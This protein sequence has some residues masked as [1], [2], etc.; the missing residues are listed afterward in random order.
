[1]VGT[2]I[3]HYRILEK[4]GAGGMGVVYKAQ[5]TRLGRFVTLKFRPDDCADN[6]QLR[7][8]FQREARTASALNHP[9]ICTIYDI[10]EAYRRPFIAMEF[11]H[12]TTLKDLVL[13]SR[14]E[15]TRRSTSRFRS[16][17]DWKRRMR[18]T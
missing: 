5:D 4:L 13:G 9:N 17:T 8:R 15:L 1:M 12:G 10:G 18:R 3:S 11:L 2:T 14:L 7:E 6:Q 16:S